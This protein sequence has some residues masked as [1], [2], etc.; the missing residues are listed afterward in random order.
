MALT[1]TA[2]KQA[3]PTGK[4]YRMFNGGVYI[5]SFRRRA[6]GGGGEGSQPWT[7][8]PNRAAII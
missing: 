8:I 6:A 4:T 7:G 1:D 5:K 2:C 3:K